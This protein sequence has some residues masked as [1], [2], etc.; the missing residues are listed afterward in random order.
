[1]H[2]KQDGGHPS[3]RM[4]LMAALGGGLE[5]YDFVIYGV[6]AQAIATAFFPGSDPLTSL[7]LS[8]AVFAVGYL[9]RPF[10]GMLISH[11][12]DRYGRKQAFVATLLTM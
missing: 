1:M 6:F 12:G 5:Y 3:G 9:A 8:L 10:G 11:C 4:V 7:T 2:S